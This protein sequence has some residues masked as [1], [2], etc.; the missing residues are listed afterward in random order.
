M[1]CL[2]SNQVS[3][4][5]IAGNLVKGEALQATLVEKT[6]LSPDTFLFSFALPNKELGLGLPT[7]QHV[8]ISLNSPDGRPVNRAYT[9]VSRNSKL[10]FVDFVIKI[11][12]KTDQFPEGGKMTQLIDAMEIGGKAELRGPFGR[13][14][15]ASKGVFVTKGYGKNKDI[16]TA[17]SNINMIC[18]GTGITP[19]LQVL[20][21]V[22]SEPDVV[23]DVALVFASK[24]P[25]DILC[26]DEIDSLVKQCGRI[27]V[28]YVVSSVPTAEAAKYTVGRVNAG[29]LEATLHKAGPKTINLTCGPP[30]FLKEAV[31]PGLLSLGHSKESIVPF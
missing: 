11:Y 3:D 6:V 21:A 24:T 27:S 10:G 28:T 16:R 20:Y 13:L 12:R 7:G 30:G 31:D 23:V 8:F 18:G 19:M 9:P 1:G 14:T 17:Y 29:V 2:Q 5:T 15:Y 4:E 22:V 25:Q 26:R